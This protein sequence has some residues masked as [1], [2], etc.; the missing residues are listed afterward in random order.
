M[1]G[2]V[3]VVDLHGYYPDNEGESVHVGDGMVVTDKALR[4]ILTHG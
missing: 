2:W 3:L 4:V 1:N